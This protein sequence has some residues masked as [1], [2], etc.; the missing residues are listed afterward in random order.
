MGATDRGILTIFMLQGLLIGLLGTIIGVSGGYFLCYVLNTYEII[1]LPADVYY[2]SHLACEDAIQRLRGGIGL[3]CCHKFFCDC[4][5][6]MAGGKA[7]PCG[8]AEI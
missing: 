5:S 6:C 7:G 2:L 4:L 3:C 8:T 1:K